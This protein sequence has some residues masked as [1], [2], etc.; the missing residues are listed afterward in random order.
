MNWLMIFVVGEDLGSYKDTREAIE[1]IGEF[2]KNFDMRDLIAQQGFN[3]VKIEHN[4]VK[5]AE[6]ILNF[7]KIKGL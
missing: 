3:K 7:I 4:F 6:K 1:L 2:L 5:R